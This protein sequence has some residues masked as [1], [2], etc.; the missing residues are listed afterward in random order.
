LT[1]LEGRVLLRTNEQAVLQDIER[2][3][4]LA[5]YSACLDDTST[6]AITRKSSDLTKRL[7]TDQLRAVFQDELVRLKFTDLAVE[8][9]PAGG[10]RGALFHHLVFTGVPGVAV[11]DVLSEGESRSLSLAAFMTELSTS[12]TRSAIIFDDPVSSLDHIWR[13]RIAVR[14]VAEA[15]GRQVIVF[16]HDLFFLRTLEDEAARVGVSCEQQYV[17]REGHE[18]GICAADL[19]W[20]AMGTKKRIGVLRNRWQ[21]AEKLARAS[22]KEAYEREAREIY[23]LLRETWE[24][25]LGEVLLADVVARYRFSI[26]TRKARVLHDI[27][28]EDCDA[29][30]DAMTEASRWMRGHDQPL[31]NGTPFPSALD[32]KKRIDDLDAWVDGIGRRRRG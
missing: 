31:A 24:Q 23:G 30:D 1:E 4:R 22:G 13:E 29:L 15:Q 7:V 16:T 19:P 27:T 12:A 11:T 5:A 26:E 20:V 2:R 9:Q 17:R 8:I 10:T 14:L 21:A 28:K 32:L 25:A 3:K 18:A 6:Q